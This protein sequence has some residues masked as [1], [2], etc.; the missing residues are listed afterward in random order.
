M[1]RINVLNLVV[2][3][4]FLAL[5]AG[6]QNDEMPD[7]ENQS[8]L[9]EN[10]KVDIPDALSQEGM[11]N[12]RT[13]ED[14]LKGNSIYEHLTTFIAIG[15]GSAEIVEDIIFGISVYQINHPMSLT[16]EGEDDGRDKNLVVV[17]NAEFDG[18]TWEFQLTV[19]DADSEGNEDGGK[20]MQVFWNRNPVKGIA[21]LKPYNIDRDND[22]V[23][24]E[25]MFRIDYS[26]AGENGYDAQ[27]TVYISDLP[28]ANPLDDPFS[29]SA[30]KMFVGKK[31]EVIDVV[32]NSNH[33][34]AI[35]FSGDAG[36]NWAFAAAGNNSED[37][38]VA[39]VGLPPSDLDETERDILLE[40]YSIKN[41][42]TNEILSV[43]PDLPQELINAYLVN[44]EAPGFFDQG[45][46][47][48]GGQSPDP[49]YDVLVE[50]LGD[51]SPY[52]PKDIS[53]LLVQFK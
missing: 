23:W 49:E 33:P 46:F 26:E 4:I 39:E 8:I 25:A 37:I 53:E 17:E 42:F 38:G 51:L 18:A 1:K 28:L 16:F 3:V 50:R 12:G 13:A 34:N 14:T 11:V 24:T 7:P 48:A 43:W 31:G 32:G 22:E 21:I 15:E 9:P 47:V 27:M 6:C 41:V 52:N 40:T 20:A 19:T 36:F 5:A 29:M 35:L 30:M 45:G 10:F 2:M 44:T